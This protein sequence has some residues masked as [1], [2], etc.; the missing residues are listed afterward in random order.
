MLHFWQWAQVSLRKC[1]ETDK[2]V[3]T[4]YY[5]Y[6]LIWVAKLERSHV[7]QSNKNKSY[8]GRSDRLS[9]SIGDELSDELKIY[10]VGMSCLETS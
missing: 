1:I 9:V 6:L 4:P 5:I 3:A 7:L 10:Q 8:R 2:R